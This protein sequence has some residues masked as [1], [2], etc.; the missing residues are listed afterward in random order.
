MLFGSCLFA[1][2]PPGAKAQSQKIAGCSLLAL[3]IYTDLITWKHQQVEEHRECCWH[4]D[5]QLAFSLETNLDLQPVQAILD[6]ASS[7]EI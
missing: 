4:V 7:P 6:T 1:F 3:E 5:A 2:P